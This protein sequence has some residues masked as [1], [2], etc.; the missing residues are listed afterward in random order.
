MLKRLL[1][2]GAAAVAMTTSVLAADIVDTAS[3]AGNFT[4]L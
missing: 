3:Q 2:S 1:I 4:T